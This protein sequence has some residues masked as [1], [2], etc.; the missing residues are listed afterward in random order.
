MFLHLPLQIE[1]GT[2]NM[3]MNGHGVYLPRTSRTPQALR[4]APRTVSAGTISRVLREGLHGLVTLLEDPSLIRHVLC[5]EKRR[6]RLGLL[7]R[8]YT[9][10][11]HF[12]SGM[13]CR[14]RGEFH[15]H[16]LGV[17]AARP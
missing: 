2:S 15:A 16:G 6:R 11:E 17:F 5:G 12:E 13:M 8:Y 1:F 3:A 14:R 10:S 7:Q 4:V 9:A